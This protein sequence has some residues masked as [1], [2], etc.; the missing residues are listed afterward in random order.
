MQFTQGRLRKILRQFQESEELRRFRKFIQDSPDRLSSPGPNGL[1]LL[2]EAI[3]TED[4]DAVS[5]VLAAGA[6]SNAKAHR[7]D[8]FNLATPLALAI[9]LGNKNIV[10]ILL[11]AGA[12]LN[13]TFTIKNSGG[14]PQMRSV[15]A[16]YYS[17]LLKYSEIED[18]LAKRNGLWV[19]EGTSYSP[20]HTAIGRNDL[21]G[22]KRM[23]QARVPVNEAG[24]YLD[25]LMHR[26]SA[27]PEFPIANAW[28]QNID[29]AKALIEGGADPRSHNL[30]S[31]LFHA[32]SAGD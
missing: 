8:I 12:D 9:K 19:T 7:Y 4:A 11:N 28:C 26:L 1:T 30:M 16:L 13:G 10:E 24:E 6:D 29:I 3:L 31:P 18:L 32:I 22:I 25:I 21:D 27:F 14:S 15:T 17:Y 2:H 23:L 5:L 20:Y